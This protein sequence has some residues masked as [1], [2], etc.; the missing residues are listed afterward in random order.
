MVTS[1]I[2]NNRLIQDRELSQETVDKIEAVHK[3]LEE[4][5][6]TKL[7]DIENIE[8]YVLD[9]SALEYEL[10][11]LWGFSQ[12]SNYHSWWFMDPKCKCPKMDNED[13]LGTKYSIYSSDCPLHWNPIDG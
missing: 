8:N 13:M 5:L 10:Q 12:D 3:E 1:K 9:I 11:H 2:L 7:E 6:A 4:L